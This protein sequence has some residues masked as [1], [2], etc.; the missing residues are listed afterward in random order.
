[1]LGL[2]DAALGHKEQALREGRRAL[3]L[4]P[5]DKDAYVGNSLIKYLGMIAAWV[6]ENDL[7]CEQLAIAVRGPTTTGYGELKLLPFWDPLRGEPCFE[8][9]VASLAPKGN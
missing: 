4:L 5:I 8:K 6:G 3:Q 9:T 1:V 2:I 7:A